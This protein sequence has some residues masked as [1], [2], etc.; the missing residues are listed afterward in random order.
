MHPMW[1]LYFMSIY[2]ALQVH[3]LH[4]RL[5]DD[6]NNCRFAHQP[7]HLDQP[8]SSDTPQSMGNAIAH[9]DFRTRQ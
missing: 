5:P 8:G 4:Q 1:V 9:A 6:L 3:L 7:T 2:K